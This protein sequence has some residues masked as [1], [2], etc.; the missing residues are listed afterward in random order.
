MK[1]E[2]QKWARNKEER[3]EFLSNKHM[4]NKNNTREQTY[5]ESLPV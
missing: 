2:M 1:Q 4:R 3:Q 5:L